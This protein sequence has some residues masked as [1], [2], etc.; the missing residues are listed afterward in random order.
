M[1]AYTRTSTAP[2]KFYM[3][4]NC[5]IRY[6]EKRLLQLKIKFILCSLYGNG[7]YSNY[8]VDPS[9]KAVGHVWAVARENQYTTACPVLYHRIQF[10]P[11]I[12]RTLALV[13]VVI[14]LKIAF[15]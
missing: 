15:A 2:P 8:T 6:S 7:Y 9:G 11:S 13:T 4:N 10:M 1:D 3:C 5:H 12:L 14:S